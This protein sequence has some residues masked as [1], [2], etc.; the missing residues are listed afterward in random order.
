MNVREFFQTALRI[1]G[2]VL[3]YRAIPQLFVH[4][5][6]VMKNDDLQDLADNLFPKIVW[7]IIIPL[8]FLIG[9]PQLTKLLFPK[10]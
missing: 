10:E 7:G 1:V 9:A 5:S 2:V 8:W 6:K 4:L 3:L